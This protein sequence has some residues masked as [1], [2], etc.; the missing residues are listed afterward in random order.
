MFNVVP[1]HRIGNAQRVPV[2][3]NVRQMQVLT[4][5]PE[6]HIELPRANVA[7]I[8]NIPRLSLSIALSWYFAYLCQLM[9]LSH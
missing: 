4:K 3:M 9:S 7:F 2:Q 8:P 5:P 1:N 6:R